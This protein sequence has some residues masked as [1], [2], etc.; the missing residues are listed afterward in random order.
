MELFERE[1]ISLDI[2]AEM[3]HEDLKQ[4]GVSAYGHRHKLIKGIEKLYSSKF[5][6]HYLNKNLIC[7]K[8]LGK[9]FI[10][11]AGK[12]SPIF[13]LRYLCKFKEQI[14]GYLSLV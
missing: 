1:Q 11:K 12:C 7:L 14:G 5:L 3:G 13:F 8:I 2:L 4:V 10:K 6:Q 9:L